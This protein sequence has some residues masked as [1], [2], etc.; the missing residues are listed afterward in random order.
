M[1]SS[2]RIAGTL[3][4]SHAGYRRFCESDVAFESC[5]HKQLGSLEAIVGL[6]RPLPSTGTA[7][8]VQA[9]T[10]YRASTLALANP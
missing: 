3:R 1:R 7:V 10:V 2:R 4:E 8:L 5:C 9:K 6:C